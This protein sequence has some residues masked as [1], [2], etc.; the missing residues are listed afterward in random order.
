VDTHCYPGYA[1][2]PFYDSLMGK[3]IVHG[4]DRDDAI[5]TMLAAL[6]RF[7]IEG[8]PTTRGFSRRIV[9]SEDFRRSAVTTDWLEKT[10]LPQY[11]SG[12]PS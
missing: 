4:T 9:A 10:F 6:N 5:E 11:L 12:N 1:I 7:V 8:V 2:P 3:L